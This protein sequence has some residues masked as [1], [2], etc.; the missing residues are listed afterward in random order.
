[1]VE[2][3]PNSGVLLALSTSVFQSGLEVSLSGL[4]VG[5][6]IS[7]SGNSIGESRDSSSEVKNL[8]SGVHELVLDLISE[9][10]V[11]S[12]SG[13]LSISFHSFGHFHVFLNSVHDVEKSLDDGL[14]GV[15]FHGFL[16]NL[17]EEFEE[18]TITV[19][20]TLFWGGEFV[21]SGDEGRLHTGLGFKERISTSNE[22]VIDDGSAVIE[23]SKDGLVL[24]SKVGISSSFSFSL[25][26]E[27]FKHSLSVTSFSDLVGE[28]LLS[29]FEGSR[30][31]SGETHEFGLISS[32]LGETTSEFSE[33]SITS[34]MFTFSNSLGIS[35]LSFESINNISHA[36]NKSIDLFSGFKLELDSRNESS[37]IFRISNFRKH[38]FKL[39]GRD[40]EDE[41]GNEEG[42]LLHF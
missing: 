14:V 8:S 7:R 34:V 20:N 11:I 6:S 21:K 18:S 4:S 32:S 24:S 9:F 1:M 35:H 16:N 31:E 15:D 13:S 37:T 33:V 30:I 2:L 27:S 41:Y 39:S 36:G 12:L 3:L 38:F 28:F 25:G 5:K 17:S 26:S 42:S 29:G 10:F 23:D 40:G 19:S 22:S